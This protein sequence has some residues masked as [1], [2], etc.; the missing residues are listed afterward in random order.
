MTITNDGE[1][2]SKLSDMICVQ[3]LKRWEEQAFP[4]NTLNSVSGKLAMQG[5]G[6]KTPPV[7]CGPFAIIAIITTLA[8]I[9]LKT[10]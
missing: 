5:R 4:Q 1:K 9:A 8:I 7:E 3:P 10:M 6:S 2:P